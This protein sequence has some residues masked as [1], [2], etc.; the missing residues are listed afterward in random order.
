MN[1]Q[2]LW[3]AFI[4]LSNL[5]GAQVGINTANPQGIFHIDGGKD[6]LKV[7]LPSIVQQAND[8]TVAMSS[9]IGAGTVSVGIGTTTPTQSLDIANGN[10]RVRNINSSVGVSGD[11]LLVA[12]SNGIVKVAGVDAFSADDSGNRVLNAA[13]GADL[14]ANDDW[15]DNMFTTLLLDVQYDPQNAYD[16]TT[17]IYT[18]K[19]D[20]LY[21]LYG[22]CGFATPG[23]GSGVFDGTSGDAFTSLYV[24]DGRVATTNAVI[25]RGDKNPLPANSFNL[26]FLTSNATIWLK[27]GQQVSLQFLTYGTNNMVGNLSDLKISKAN[28]R[29]IINKLL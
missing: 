29:L 27:A 8:F 25:H 24:D 16:P 13:G 28:S 6:N 20:G 2:L 18:V 7:G 10:L 22:V 9:L 4:V 11:K 3:T 15:N 14:N 26:Y 19:K 17:G 21:F 1:K 23:S 5:V 12:D